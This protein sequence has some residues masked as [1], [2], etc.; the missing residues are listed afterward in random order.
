MPYF[1]KGKWTYLDFPPEDQK[2][3]SCLP[4]LMVILRE[5]ERERA[6]ER[7]SKHEWRRDTQSEEGSRLRAIST[8]PDTGLKLMNREIMTWADVG[9][10]SDWATQAPL[11]VL[12]NSILRIAFIELNTCILVLKSNIYSKVLTGQSLSLELFQWKQ[13][14]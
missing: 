8:E 13:F 9:H 10:S 7:A 2:V 14:K 12:F 5:R 1:V 6:R 3:A 11:N 4:F